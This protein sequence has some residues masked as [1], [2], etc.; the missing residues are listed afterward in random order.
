[1]KK[2]KKIL[3][4]SGVSALAV[5]G[6]AVLAANHNKFGLNVK[7]GEEEKTFNLNLGVAATEGKVYAEH[8]NTNL[9]FSVT[10]EYSEAAGATVLSTSQ[11]IANDEA[12]AGITSIYVEGGNGAYD[13]FAG[14]DAEHMYKFA[15]ATSNGGD[16]EFA[17]LPSVNYI[18]LVGKYTGSFAAKIKSITFDYT[19]TEN[20]CTY[21]AATEIGDTDA[22]AGS[23]VKGENTL[24]I[25]ETLATATINEDTFNYTGIVYNNAVLYAGENTNVLL[26]FNEETIAVLDTY[27][28]YSS[29]SGNYAVGHELSAINFFV[30]GEAAEETAEDNRFVMFPGEH[31]T[32]KA[33]T[34]AIPPVAVNYEVTDETESTPAAEA[35]IFVGTYVVPTLD[36]VDYYYAFENLS[37]TVSQFEIALVNDEYLLTYADTPNA[38]TDSEYVA[39]NGTFVGILSGS[40]LTFDIDE[41]V[42]ITV[43]GDH[44]VSAIYVDD[45]GMFYAIADDVQATYTAPEAGEE[46]ID[47]PTVEMEEEIDEDWPTGNMIITAK[48][49][50]NAYIKVTAGN[51]VKY[52]F[53]EVIEETYHLEI[54]ASA[55]TFEV[56]ST[57]NT[58]GVKVY[59][60][61]NERPDRKMLVTSDCVFSTPDMTTTGTKTVTVIYGELTATYEIEVVEAAPAFNLAGKWALTNTEF[62]DA[63]DAV[64]T[65]NEGFD[66]NKVSPYV[67]VGS[68]EYF[69]DSFGVYVLEA[70]E[71]LVTF[72]VYTVGTLYVYVNNGLFTDVMLEEEYALYDT[73]VYDF[74]VIDDE[75]ET[76]CLV[77]IWNMN[78]SQYDLDVVLTLNDG[79]DYYTVDNQTT[80]GTIEFDGE[81]RLYV[82]HVDDGFVVF[83]IDNGYGTLNLYYFDGEITDASIVEEILYYDTLVFDTIERG[84][85]PADTFC[86]VGTWNLVADLGEDYNAVLTLNDGFDYY[87]VSEQV[88]VG[89]LSYFEEY[90][91]YLT[92]LNEGVATFEVG[93]GAGSIDVSFADGDVTGAV[94]HEQLAVYDDIT[95]TIA[96]EAVPTILNFTFEDGD[97]TE[98]TV[99]YLEGEYII[100]DEVYTFEFDGNNYVND[101]GVTL[102]YRDAGAVSYLDFTDDDMWFYFEAGIAIYDT[103]GSIELA[104]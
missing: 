40:D 3:I 85:N 21:G 2:N 38:G 12:L 90:S 16:R 50:G 41:E 95:Y 101:A 43:T 36:F 54:E 44:L 58:N 104:D 52:F 98:H 53:I 22:F 19:A 102:S 39:H 59:R 99:K 87:T 13:L 18:A 61:S 31:I 17:N 45:D 15:T 8:K 46:E 74:A 77:G 27:N 71:G 42:S 72:E 84:E 30:N 86:L 10:G 79:F 34:D 89:T 4:L 37:V 14:Y 66:Y 80:V 9:P 97:S 82:D 57:F 88:A 33:T 92:A 49:A 29:I 35:D 76:L 55:T 25:D 26:T 1:M 73:I 60:V 75:P 83:E 5:A 32:F 70:G 94:Y 62:G 64:L 103:S 48:D 51:M 47:L 78:C 69:G 65:L 6:A 7:A 20:V 28:N 23:F 56:N 81:H 100:I 96:P 63:Y 91:L 93:S 11:I 68:F 24:V 67:A